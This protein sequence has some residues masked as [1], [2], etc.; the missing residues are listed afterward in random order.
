MQCPRIDALLNQEEIERLKEILR[1]E[2]SKPENKK[3]GI[4]HYI[5]EIEGTTFHEFYKEILYF[6]KGYK[7]RI[8][9]QIKT[10]LIDGLGNRRFDLARFQ[11]NARQR[12]YK[13]KQKDWHLFVNKSEY[14][15]SLYT[16]SINFFG[17]KNEDYLNRAYLGFGFEF[18]LKGI[19]LKKGYLINKVVN[20][21]QFI[22]AGKAI[23]SHPIKLGAVTKD[24][25]KAE[26]YGFDHWINQIKRIKPLK[27]EDRDF[28]YYIL[29][30]LK[31]AQNW[32]NKDVHTP[33]GYRMSDSVIQ[34]HLKDSH[35]GL[36]HLFLRGRKIPKFLN[37]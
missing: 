12:Y 4:F 13:F 37:L 34:Q 31:I 5:N 26:V 8:D 22:L 19:F 18:L 21:N 33:T 36:Y 6:I 11:K 16:S 17:V 30:G 14:F 28:D 27:V 2:Y 7:K 24:F 23:P 1:L 15:F 10:K 25:I 9:V 32:R 35:D 29:A 3:Y 20:N